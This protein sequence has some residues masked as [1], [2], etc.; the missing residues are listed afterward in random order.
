[1]GQ[2]SLDLGLLSGQGSGLL[3]GRGLVRRGSRI[4]YFA[5]SVVGRKYVDFFLFCF[6]FLGGGLK[7]YGLIGMVFR[8]GRSA[9]DQAHKSTAS[10]CQ[11]GTVFG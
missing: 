6:F 3:Q 8:F 11:L 9:Y 10:S 4:W 1:M 7:D 5:W 2:K